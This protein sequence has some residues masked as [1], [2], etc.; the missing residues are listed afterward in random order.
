MTWM[1]EAHGSGVVLRSLAHA[2]YQE[3]LSPLGCLTPTRLR[4]TVRQGLSQ[5]HGQVVGNW[6]SSYNI[7]YLKS[8]LSD[9]SIA[10]PAFL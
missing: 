1:P 6:I 7:L 2:T 9:I 4:V 10:I 8:V 3:N 5:E